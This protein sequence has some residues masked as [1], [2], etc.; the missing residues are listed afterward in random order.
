MDRLWRWGALNWFILLMPALLLIGWLAGRAIPWAEEGRA[1]E[2]ALLIDACV[3]LPVLYAL[4]YC[5]RLPH[6]QLVIRLLG[7]ACLGIYLIGQV[8]PAEHQALLPAFSWARSIGLG[9]LILIELWLFVSVLRLVFR[10]GTTAEQ[11]TAKTG[12][13]PL[14]AKLLLLEAR[15]WSAVWRF[16]RGR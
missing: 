15:F 10:S 4:C 14:I 13:P 5:G 1:M 11:L 7:I 9:F 6:W 2:T 12:A 16:L 3:T 8:V